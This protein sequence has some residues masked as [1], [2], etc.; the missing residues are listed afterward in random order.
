[1]SCLSDWPQK[2]FRK[3]WKKNV[4]ITAKQFRETFIFEIF[5]AFFRKWCGILNQLFEIILF[6][7]GIHSVL[8]Y[9]ETNGKIERFNYFFSNILIISNVVFLLSPLLYSTF[10]YYVLNLG[11]GS[12]LLF[13]PAW[14][15]IDM[16]KIRKEIWMN[17]EMFCLCGD[18]CKR[19][20][21]DWRTP[22]GYLV[23]W[24]TQCVEGAS[25]VTT[26]VL[27]LGI[28]FGSSWLFIV[29]AKDITNYLDVFNNAVATLK[30]ATTDSDRTELVKH[31]CENIRNYAD[32]KQW[33]C[34]FKFCCLSESNDI[35]QLAPFILQIDRRLQWNEQVF[36]VRILCMDHAV[37]IQLIDD[38]PIS[39]GWV[40][41]WNATNSI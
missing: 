29:I 6:F 8:I 30:E 21:F 28:V 10:N 16:V 25:I 2:N 17:D 5:R 23:A 13:C 14:F 18:V 36:I 24:V 38:T 31:F 26:D 37:Y 33:V 39:I 41:I 19:L 12:F 27:F 1:M 11:R 15:V 22:L 7:G 9:N 32:A 20:P 4:G 40:W 3:N 34:P 35:L